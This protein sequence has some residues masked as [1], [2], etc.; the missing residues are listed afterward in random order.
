VVGEV[1]SGWTGIPTGKMVKD[2]IA[3]VLKL[4]DY[5]ATRIIGRIMR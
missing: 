1:I 3:A 2:E 5:L 4:D